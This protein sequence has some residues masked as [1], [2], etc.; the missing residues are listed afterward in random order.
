M[1]RRTAWLGTPPRPIVTLA[2]LSLALG[3]LPACAAKLE[4]LMPTPALFT[5][6]GVDPMAHIP[7]EE[8]WVPRRVFYATTRERT[9]TRRDIAYGNREADHLSMGVA[10]VGF[11]PEDMT[12]ADLRAATVTPGT[13]GRPPLTIN[14]VFEAGRFAVDATADQAAEPNRAGWVLDNIDQAVRTARDPDILVYVHGAKV[15]F[16]NACAFAAQLDHF[17]GRDLTSLAFAWPTHQSILS[18]GVG[19]DVG[20]AYHAAPALATLLEVLASDTSARRIHVLCWSAG[21]RVTSRAMALLRER[22][23]DLDHA[24]LQE[25]LRLGTVYFA[26]ADVPADQFLEALPAIHDLSREVVVT[27][28]DH[29]GALASAERFMGGEARIG[30]LHAATVAEEHRGWLL[31][32]ERFHVI[33]VSRGSGE[34]GFD[35]TGHRYWFNHPWASSDVV[36]S[37]RTDLSPAERGLVGTAPEDQPDRDPIVWSIPADYPDRLRGLGAVRGTA[38]LREW[39]PEADPVR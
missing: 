16:Y 35:I 11:G 34:R 10:L 18:Y 39:T 8:R 12:W 20:R 21:G 15:D 3:L 9:S 28:S 14:G 23:P 36:L 19:G 31:D 27:Q 24:E 1:H 25:K 22:H 29:D 26:A 17:M 7:E 6:T 4:P 38:P 13:D 5:E 37:I 32:L 2:L 30:L 33:N